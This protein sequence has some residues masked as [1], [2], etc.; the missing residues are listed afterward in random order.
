M[1]CTILVLR[2]LPSL[3]LMS[4]KYLPLCIYLC[5]NLHMVIVNKS[6][7]PFRDPLWSTCTC[8]SLLHEFAYGQLLLSCVADGELAGECC[9]FFWREGWEQRTPPRAKIPFSWNPR[10][11]ILKGWRKPESTENSKTVFVVRNL[12]FA[13]SKFKV[14]KFV[15]FT[16]WQLRLSAKYRIAP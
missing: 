7:S 2:G 5:E 4:F 6:S 13:S 15:S 12:I 3:A 11:N 1:I 8:W 10:H 16:L 9:V 14:I